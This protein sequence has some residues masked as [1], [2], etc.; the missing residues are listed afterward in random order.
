MPHGNLPVVAKCNSIRP[1]KFGKTHETVCTN[2]VLHAKNKALCDGWALWL[3]RT[4]VR[5]VRVRAASGGLVPCI[6]I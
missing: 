5:S 6:G 4:D 1:D 2:K 3:A